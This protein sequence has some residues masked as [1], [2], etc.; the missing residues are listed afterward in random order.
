MKSI[1]SKVAVIGC[2]CLF[3][4]SGVFADG[5]PVKK[6]DDLIPRIRER[7][8]EFGWR[9]RTYESDDKD[10]W[11]NSGVGVGGYIVGAPPGVEESQMTMA[12]QMLSETD[13]KNLKDEITK[14]MEGVRLQK[15]QKEELDFYLAQIE[16][17]LAS[18]KESFQVMGGGIYVVKKNDSLWLIA[19][20]EYGDANKWPLIYRA[21][22]DKIRNPNVIYS[23]QELQIPQLKIKK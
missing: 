6:Q 23:G 22:Q 14:S 16:S 17:Q 1:I 13:L 21:N 18:Y 10:I 15:K 3:I 19:R 2:I 5:T 9:V 11:G 4:C 12:P 20:K 8:K 7:L